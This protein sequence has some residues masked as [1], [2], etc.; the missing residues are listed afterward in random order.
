MTPSPPLR[1]YPFYCQHNWLTPKLGLVETVDKAIETDGWMEHNA[2]TQTL[3]NYDAAIVAFVHSVARLQHGTHYWHATVER[4]TT[5]LGTTTTIGLRATRHENKRH[6]AVVL[7]ATADNYGIGARRKTRAGKLRTVAD[8]LTR[9]SKSAVG[10][11]IMG[12]GAMKNDIHV[13][14]EFIELTN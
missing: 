7:L 3:A 11:T 6:L 8:M 2:L 10:R 9:Y 14:I 13:F 1:L 12:A 5:L 4:H